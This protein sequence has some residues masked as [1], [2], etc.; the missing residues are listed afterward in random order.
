MPDKRKR[1]GAAWRMIRNSPEAQ[2]TIY[3]IAFA[4][5]I[6]LYTYIF[7]TFY[8]V[9][10]NKTL[11]W[12]EALLFVVESMTTVGYG[13]LLPFTNDLTRVLAIQIMLSGVIM[14]FIVVP[15]LLAPFLTT[16]LAPTPPRRT[17]HALDDHIVIIGYDE[18][19]R[20]L[21]ESLTISDHE[22]VIIEEDKAL[23]LEIGA[24]FRRR[25]Y[26]IWGEY[27]DP[28]TWAAAHI[29][30]ASFTVISKDER[31]TANIVLGIRRMAKGKIIAVVD[32]LAFDRY[33]RY[34]GADFV[35]SPKYATGR[36]LAHHTVL[37]HSHGT[38]AEIPGLDRLSIDAID[39]EREELR[40][41]NIPV[42][43]GSRATGRSLK[44]LDLYNRFGIVVLFLWKNG[45]F[46]AEPDA[47]GIVDN[48]TSLF[49]FGR[50]DRILAAIRDE[51]DPDG[52]TDTRAVIA[53]YGDVG[54]AA[55]S[56]LQAAG[57]SC[58]IADSK[59]HNLPQQVIGNAEDEAVLRQAGIDQAQFC[60]V[61]LN[62]DDVNI[63]T[64]LMARNLNP[65]IRIL[66]RANEPKSVDKMYRA[67]ADYVTLL[68][69]IGAQIIGRI[70]LADLITVILDLPDGSMVIMKQ[71]TREGTRTSTGSLQRR[72]GVKII[73][74]EREGQTI[75]TPEPQ[76][77]VTYGDRIFAVGDAEQLKRFLHAV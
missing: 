31:L 23:A 69:T 9:L 25:A 39:E 61:A 27:T 1:R 76:E 43:A 29:S 67:G 65:A 5:L 35:L 17:S 54:A 28:A 20:S 38:L 77:S 7:H 45:A 36:I 3:F 55:Y 34:A 63:F 44:E 47:S 10:E 42:M 58:I 73:G 50:A 22:I 24:R 74:I 13:W 15:L 18:L 37:R 41:I 49:L 59:E 60:I 12:S 4:T 53:G 6:G 11:T 21:I 48:S 26:V 33:L 64:T 2:I 75:V 57:I 71:T 62:N 14:I 66:A 70:I 51:F 40:L 16:L 19:T 72:S 56:E 46:V 52:N 68:P 8:P 30:D 32:K